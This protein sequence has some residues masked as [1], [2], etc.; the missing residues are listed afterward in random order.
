MIFHSIIP[1]DEVFKGSDQQESEYVDVD[2]G[3]VK[4]QIRPTGIGQGRLVRLLSTDPLDYL[5]P[6]YQPGSLVYW[7]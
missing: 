2:V 5:R 1:L 3:S 6:E 4:M 7:K